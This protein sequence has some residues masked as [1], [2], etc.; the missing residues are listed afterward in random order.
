MS[1]IQISW[2]RVRYGR[3]Y[4]TMHKRVLGTQR[5]FRF[6]RGFKVRKSIAEELMEKLFDLSTAMNTLATHIEQV[7]VEEQKL[8]L[9]RGIA[10]LMRSLYADLMRP[11]IKEYPELDPDK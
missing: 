10:D 3:T 5:I 7:D 6:Q 11:V 4:Q 1:T 8:T 9:R 2:K